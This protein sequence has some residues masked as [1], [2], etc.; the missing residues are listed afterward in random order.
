[1]TSRRHAL[2][3]LWGRLGTLWG[4]F[5]D[6][7]NVR[8]LGNFASEAIFIVVGAPL[9]L[10]PPMSFPW[11]QRACAFHGQILQKRVFFFLLFFR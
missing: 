2:G 6:V 8:L 10:P 9:D 7:T 1:M 5:G 11:V 4:R 3:S